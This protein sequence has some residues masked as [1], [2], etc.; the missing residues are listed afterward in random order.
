M[1]CPAVIHVYANLGLP[2]AV[3]VTTPGPVGPIGSR[4]LGGTAAPAANLGVVG[5][6]YLRS[7]GAVYGPKTEAGWGS[8]VFTLQVPLSTASAQPLAAQAAAGS[9]GL[10]ADAGHQHPFPTASQ[11]GAD[12]Q[13]TA[14]SAVTGHLQAVDPHPQYLT[15]AEG[16]AAYATAAQGALAASAVQSTDSRLSDSREWSAATVDQVEAEA[17]TATTRRAWTAQRVHQAA[18]A[19]WAAT[20]S[21]FGRNWFALTDAAAGRAALGIANASSSVPG[22]VSLPGSSSPTISAA[23]NTNISLGA[24]QPDTVAALTVNAGTGPYTATVTLTN[25]NAYTGAFLTLILDL[26]ASRNPRIEIRNL[27]SSG[28]VLDEQVCNGTAFK[29]VV[30]CVFNAAGNW[31]VVTRT[32]EVQVFDFTRTTAPAGATGGSGA[33]AFSLPRQARYVELVAVAGGGG[34]GSGRRGAAGTN[35]SGGAGGGPGGTTIITRPVAGGELLSIAVGAGGLGGAGQTT[36]DTNGNAG[37]T[38]G[39]SSCSSS[40][41][42]WIVAGSG[43]PGAG[44]TATT[45]T[46]GP[47]APGSSMWSI[48]GGQGNVSQGGDAPINAAIPLS[49]GGSGGGGVNT[50][51][52]FGP[53]YR[54]GVNSSIQAGAFASSA[55]VEGQNGFTQTSVDTTFIYGFPGGGGGAG[56]SAGAGGNG[57]NGAGIGAGGGGGGGCVNGFTSGAGGNGIDGILRI[58]CYY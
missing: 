3:V 29:S 17:G 21:V 48:G 27:T 45:F 13:G 11:V 41:R 55:T 14:S 12:P 54:G 33:W 23:G 16:D 22:L 35:R 31:E 52:V 10:A 18:A 49:A 43:Q 39:N 20:G 6:W 24:V 9:T 28:T 53:G 40:G 56:N 34:G 36:N 42:N 19:W 4:W 7:T 26:P 57:A 51:N 5:D 47:G 8:V 1:S 25:T 46:S 58:T 15:A 50:S 2:K 44:G 30:R 32:P 38:G 37:S